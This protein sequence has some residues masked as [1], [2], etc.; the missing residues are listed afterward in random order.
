MIEDTVD[1]GDDIYREN[2]QFQ[3]HKY[4]GIFLC[5]YIG[6]YMIPVIALLHYLRFVFKPLFL[7]VSDIIVLLTS[8]DSLIIF[9]TFPLVIISFYLIRLYLVGLLTRLFWRYTE[10]K[11]P[12]KDGIIPRNITSKTLDYYHYRSF[13]IKYG[14]NTFVKGI[15]PWLANWFFNFVGASIIEKGSTIEESVLNDRNIHVKRNVYIGVNSSLASHVVEG[16]G[17]NIHYFQVKVGDNSTLGGQN[18]VGPGSELKD[19][20][21]LLPMA[22]ATKFNT[23]KGNN[24]Y[25]GMPLRRIFKKK[26]M[27]YL[28]VSEEDLHRAEELR[29]KKE[30]EKVE[31]IK[32]VENSKERELNKQGENRS[33]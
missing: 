12:T 5:I 20:T 18:V 33:E 2:V 3:Y 30:I 25:Y 16:I 10:K 28:K 29:I 17:G 23:T 21:Y 31:R 1:S 19:N 6:S 24:Y 7:G 26:I 13:M 14:K 9:L 4:F 11:S 27:E 32:K 15:F 22:A 8:F